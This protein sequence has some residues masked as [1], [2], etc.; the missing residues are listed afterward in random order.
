MT[1][2]ACTTQKRKRVNFTEL[3]DK[4]LKF[5]VER[6]GENNWPQVSACMQ[7]K[8]VRQCRDRWMK[9]LSPNVKP[10]EWS[11][12]EDALL[13]KMREK[14]GAKWTQIVNFFSGR[15]DIQLKNRYKVL[16]RRQKAAAN[17]NTIEAGNENENETETENP[18]DCINFEPDSNDEESFLDSPWDDAFKDTL[19]S[20]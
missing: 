19:F 10:H 1:E 16:L 17:T 20:F 6:F 7:T 15:T 5:Y 2:F 11:E 4:M 18:F 3:D 14:Y 13:L 8:N 9:Y 12:E